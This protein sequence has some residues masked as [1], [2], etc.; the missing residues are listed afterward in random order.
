MSESKGQN[1][2]A[3]SEKATIGQR[4]G[5]SILGIFIAGICVGILGCIAGVFIGGDGATLIW[6][7]WAALAGAAY[8][9]V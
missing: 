7:M 2:T 3:V 5:G 1:D 6:G 9:L 4:I 8:G